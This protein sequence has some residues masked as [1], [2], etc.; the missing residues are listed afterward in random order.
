MLATIMKQVWVEA[1]KL[2]TGK[3]MKINLNSN[4]VQKKKTTFK[5]QKV[6]L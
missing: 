6:F 5:I 3:T 4:L 1:Q 2:L